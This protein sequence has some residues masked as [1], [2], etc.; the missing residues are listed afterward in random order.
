MDSLFENAQ[1]DHVFFESFSLYQ[2]LEEW[3]IAEDTQE[4]EGFWILRIVSL[5]EMLCME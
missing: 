3:H 2:S 5:K 4:I 1:L